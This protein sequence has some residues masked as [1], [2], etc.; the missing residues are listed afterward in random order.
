MEEMT[1]KRLTLLG[2]IEKI[3]ELSV[4]KG[5]NDAFF[6][7]AKPHISYVSKKLKLTAMQTVLFAHM[8][9]HGDDQR[10]YLR[11]IAEPLK[12]NNIKLMQYMDDFDILESKKLIR[13][14]RGDDITYRV[15]KEVQTT[16]R[17]G[18]NYVPKDYRNIPIG[19]LFTVIEDLFELRKNDELTFDDI[20]AELRS[21][22]DDNMHLEFCKKL[23]ASNLTREDAILL[24]YFCLLYVRDND[25]NI[26]FYDLEDIFSNHG[27]GAFRDI[28]Q[29]LECG[30]CLLFEM[31]LIEYTYS[32]GF[33]DRDSFKLTDKAKKELL[34]ELNL[35]RK[36]NKKDLVPADGIHEKKMFYNEKEAVRITEL[37]ALLQAENFARVQER[38]TGSNMRRGFACLFSGAPGTGKTETAY[39]IARETKRDIMLV[40][41]SETKSMWFG[42]SEKRIKE[43]FNNY[44]AQV[45]RAEKSAEN[46]P[47]LLFNEA[48]AV[49][50]KRQSLSDNHSGPGQ[51]E[52]AIQNIILQEMENLNG[53]LIATTNLTRNMDKAFERRF[54]YKI[55][56]EKPG[57]SARQAIWQCM[58]D[59]LPEADAVELALRFDFSGGQIENIARKRTVNSVL[60]GKAPGLE[61]LLAYCREESL[62]KSAPVLGFGA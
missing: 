11:Q 50:G 13:C 53:I 56:F 18:E 6:E 19:E 38:L 14:R 21:L 27:P 57:R 30:D 4:K 12:C 32:E 24:V 48:D 5:L 55:E 39:Q 15:P 3:V 28:K 41:I 35:N 8:L 62:Y 2:H 22:Q 29:E 58:I 60:S 26:T 31:G 49:I 10:I 36:A 7:N 1:A 47:I 34:A 25:D 52:N 37:K 59:D 33:V 45:E 20:S 61:S 16:L 42:E 51:T 54:L 44:Q 46:I 40:D 9:N 43:V 23:A 17:K